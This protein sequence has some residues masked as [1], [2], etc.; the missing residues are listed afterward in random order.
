MIQK[1]GLFKSRAV[2]ALLVRRLHRDISGG[3]RIFSHRNAVTFCLRSR[4][5]AG[6]W[7]TSQQM[8]YCS[9]VVSSPHPELTI[10]REDP[11][12]VPHFVIDALKNYSKQTALVSCCQLLD[13]HNLWLE[14]ETI[15]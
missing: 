10:L 7:M 13:R 12:S 3:S 9:N 5:A 15:Y 2:V 1:L 8:M 6:W 14:L 11:P 4:S